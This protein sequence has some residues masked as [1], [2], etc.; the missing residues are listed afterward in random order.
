ML[1]RRYIA[2]E[3]GLQAAGS[4]RASSDFAS[5]K[6]HGHHHS[7]LV[8]LKAVWGFSTL[9]FLDN[10]DW[11]VPLLP[12]LVL[13]DDKQV[14]GMVSDVLSKHVNPIVLDQKQ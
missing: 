2:L 3:V 12:Q 5:M 14:R 4:D 6:L 10:K 11:I 1:F 9:Q 13:C 7:V 8:A